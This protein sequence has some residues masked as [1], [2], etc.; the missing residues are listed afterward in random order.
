MYDP[1]PSPNRPTAPPYM[2]YIEPAGG[3]TP[4]P[5]P[6]TPGPGSINRDAGGML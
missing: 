2:P 3:I 4:G 5:G 6:P 1:I